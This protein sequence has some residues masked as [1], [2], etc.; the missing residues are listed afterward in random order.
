M[1]ATLEFPVHKV[2]VIF[3]EHTLDAG[4]DFVRHV[5]R[6]LCRLDYQVRALDLGGKITPVSLNLEINYLLWTQTLHSCLPS[7]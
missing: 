6:A 3:S 2:R 4:V 5:A 1:V 7:Y